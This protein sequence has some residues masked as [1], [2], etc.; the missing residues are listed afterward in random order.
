MRKVITVLLAICMLM[1]LASCAHKK[2]SSASLNNTTTGVDMGKLQEIYPEFF[3]LKGDPFKGVE[4]Y[5][6]QMSEDSYSCGLMFGTNRTKTDEEI[7]DLTKK[8]LTIDEAKAILDQCANKDEVFIIPVIQPISSYAYTIDDEYIKKVRDLFPDINPA[9]VTTLAAYSAPVSVNETDIDNLFSKV[10][11]AD[12]ALK[13]AKEKGIVVIEDAITCVSGK[14]TMESFYATVSEGNAASILIAQYYGPL[15]KSQVSNELYEQEKDNYPVLYFY[16]V[17]FDGKQF[18]T[19]V[20][21]STSEKIES[22]KTFTY[23]KHFT[24]NAPETALIAKYEYYV[25]V[26][27]EDVT[28]EDIEKGMFSSQLGDYIEHHT[29]FSDCK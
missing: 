28:W 26:D 17:E 21:E 14:E 13:A 3:N 15:K 19:K 29:I 1:A 9:L 10:C 7:W 20:R 18:T 23:L 8:A 11:P 16:M 4:V 24:G 6:W 12:E 25:L 5:V 22:E 27:N 2:L